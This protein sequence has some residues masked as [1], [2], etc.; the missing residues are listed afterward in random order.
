MGSSPSLRTVFY[1][2]TDLLLPITFFSSTYLIKFHPDY[3]FDCYPHL[4]FLSFLYCFLDKFSIEGFCDFLSIRTKRIFKTPPSILRDSVRV[5]SVS[6]R[7]TGTPCPQLLPHPSLTFLF[8]PSSRPPGTYG[9]TPEHEF[10][11]PFSLG[12]GRARPNTVLS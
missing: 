12:D 10:S 2:N 4:R 8:S 6:P 5:P 9:S 7:G 11:R 1:T 3:S